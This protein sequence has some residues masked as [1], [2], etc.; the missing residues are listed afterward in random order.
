MSGKMFCQFQLVDSPQPA[1]WAVSATARCHADWEVRAGRRQA[2]WWGHVLEQIGR[3][4]C[5]V[6]DEVLGLLRE[7]EVACQL[8]LRTSFNQ[9]KKR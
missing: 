9:L 2:G 5:I 1:G 7:A 8:S 4:P 6:V 3:I